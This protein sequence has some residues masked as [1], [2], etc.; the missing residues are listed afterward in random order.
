MNLN[1]LAAPTASFNCLLEN[2][3]PA[4]KKPKLALNDQLELE[5]NQLQYLL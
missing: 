5:L 3:N 4:N 1:Q 2:K